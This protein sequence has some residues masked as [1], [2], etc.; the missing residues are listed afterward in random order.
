VSLLALPA[1]EACRRLVLGQLAEAAQASWRLTDPADGEA[2]HDF[3]V[4]LRRL[5]ATLRAYAEPLASRL[6]GKWRKRLGKVAGE[7]GA[8]RD[9]EVALEWVEAQRD[10]LGRHHRPG[11]DRLAERLAARKEESYRAV[12]RRVPGRFAPLAERL[13]RRLLDDAPETAAEVEAGTTVASGT[14]ASLEGSSAASD[15]LDPA[16]A[17]TPDSGAAPDPAASTPH[18]DSGSETGQPF[19]ALLAAATR[20]RAA[21]LADRLGRVADTA[22]ARPAHRARIAAK[23][24]RYLLEPATAEVP[25]AQPPVKR[26]K[27]LQDLLGELQD[28]HVLAGERVA[29]AERAAA[30]EGGRLAAAV[31]AGDE[32]PPGRRWRPIHGLLELAR[33]NRERRERLFEELG[34]EWLEGEETARL[35]AG[36]EALADELE[37]RLRACE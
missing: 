25:A 10:S 19:A 4:A 33:R 21:A 5:R 20:R 7:T 17:S 27:R 24:L 11:A 22:D 37:G 36:V 26:L 12:R 32:P 8:G 15:L 34:R 13:R 31:A 3:R 18:P 35:L 6:G 14:P 2:L 9:A 23:R 30:E 28:A 1:G 16:T 29:A